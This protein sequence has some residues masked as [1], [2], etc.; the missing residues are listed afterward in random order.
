MNAI[1]EDSESDLEHHKY[2]PKIK[3]Q[4]SFREMILR[5]EGENNRRIR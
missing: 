3:K 2:K 5:E 4:T 1:K